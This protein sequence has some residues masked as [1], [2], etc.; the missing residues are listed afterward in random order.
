MV[1][2]RVVWPVVV[3]VVWL[4]VLIRPSLFLPSIAPA[5]PLPLLHPHPTSRP[6]SSSNGTYPST[7]HSYDPSNPSNNNATTPSSSNSNNN[8]NNSTSNS[9]SSTSTTLPTSSLPAIKL[10]SDPLTNYPILACLPTCFIALDGKFKDTNQAFCTLLHYNRD[11]LLQTTLF[12]VTHPNE[13]MSTFAQLKRLLGGEVDCWEGPKLLV[14]GDGGVLSVHMTIT[15]AKKY[16]KPDLYVGFFVPKSN[17]EGGPSP[18]AHATPSPQPQP[19]MQP[20]PPQPVMQ[21]MYP[22][23]P[24]PQMRPPM[25]SHPAALGTLS[26]TAGSSFTSYG[27][28]GGPYGGGE[29]GGGGAMVSPHGPGRGAL[30]GSSFMA[31]PQQGGGQGSGMA[32]GHGGGMSG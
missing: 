9:A 22:T 12:T 7:F 14:R 24:P 4:V 21:P 3:V 13:L 19:H 2:W 11:Q 26:R 27:P 30:S 10:F 25:P 17:S 18:P 1:V 32:T 15:C 31:P 6:D 8:G 29:A 23:A 5:L 20:P 16:G 28:S